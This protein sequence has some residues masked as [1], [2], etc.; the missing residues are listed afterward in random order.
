MKEHCW[1]LTSIFILRVPNRAYFGFCSWCYQRQLS[2]HQGCQPPQR[3]TSLLVP[4]PLSPKPPF[5][6]TEKN[7]RAGISSVDFQPDVACR[8]SV[9]N[10]PLYGP[11]S[12]ILYTGIKNWE[13]YYPFSPAACL[14]ICNCVFGGRTTKDMKHVVP[15]S[16][17]QDLN[18]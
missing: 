2:L 9:W 6:L 7:Q 1:K 18:K 4:S 3:N 16:L 14:M 12:K 13:L 17:K 15:R 11:L 8:R 10:Q 5:H